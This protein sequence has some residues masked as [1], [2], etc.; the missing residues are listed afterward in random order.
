[1]GDSTQVEL[2]LLKSNEGGSNSGNYSTLEEDDYNSHPTESGNPT[3]SGYPNDDDA[4]Q[5]F[6]KPMYSKSTCIGTIFGCF[7]EENG[8][9]FLSPE[10]LRILIY[11]R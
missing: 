1:M 5:S 3:N 2:S 9:M 6:P 4:D 8:Y 7:H 10:Y 11:T